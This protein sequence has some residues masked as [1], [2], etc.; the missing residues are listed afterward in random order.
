MDFNF[1][2]TLWGIFTVLFFYMALREWKK[3]KIDLKSLASLRPSL[4]GRVEILG[5]N[6]A[7]MLDK[8]K[9]EIN[10]SNKESHRIAAISYSLAGLTAF[11]S[12]IISIINLN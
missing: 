6:F 9:N 12:F 1:L 5:I 8:F 7:D 10:Q 3:T 2:L 4:V 11:A